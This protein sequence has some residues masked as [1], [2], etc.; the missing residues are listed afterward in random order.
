MCISYI[1]GTLPDLEEM[2]G[3]QSS[4]KMKKGLV[5]GSNEDS[6]KSRINCIMQS[7]FSFGKSLQWFG[8]SFLILLKSAV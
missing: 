1:C 6:Q 3:S 8:L 4:I 7:A 5:E 2:P